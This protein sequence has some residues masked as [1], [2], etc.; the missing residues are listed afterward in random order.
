MKLLGII[1]F[2]A[3]CATCSLSTE[4]SDSATDTGFIRAGRRQQTSNGGNPNGGGGG[5][6]DKPDP[7]VS[8]SSK[9]EF[10]GAAPKFKYFKDKDSND[11]LM[12]DFKQM[13]ELDDN[14]SSIRYLS[15]W[16]SK[17]FVWTRE[18]IVNDDDDVEITKVTLSLEDVSLGS[19]DGG[20]DNG[21]TASF[22]IECYM[23]EVR[24][25]KSLHLS[26]F[27]QFMLPLS[28]SCRHQENT[29][30]NDI[31]VPAGGFKLALNISHW[32][33]HIL[34]YYHKCG[35]L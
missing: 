30:I 13:S 23:P 3:L 28:P 21:D 34:D 10:V 32:Y 14:G 26:L 22:S 24:I 18:T 17:D 20:N 16:A 35:V 2:L 9:V 1:L 7:M 8:E 19:C 31:V 25:S 4:A 12:V 6:G 29:T 15:G 33:V 27:Y 11:F 5:Q